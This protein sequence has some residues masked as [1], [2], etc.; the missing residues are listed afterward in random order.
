M[1]LTFRFVIVALAVLVMYLFGFFARDLVAGTP[2]QAS[3]LTKIV[4]SANQETPPPSR[5]FSD[6]FALISSRHIHSQDPEKLIHAGMEGLVA[7]LGD[8]HTN[9][10]R[11]QV[12]EQFAL[13]TKG[14]FVGIG[15]R[16]ADDPLGARIAVVFPDGPA[17][18]SG[19]QSG[20]VISSVD[21]KPVAGQAVDEIVEQIRGEA[22]TK[23]RLGI[24]RD[25]KPVT[26]TV[27]RRRVDIPTV[28][29]EML[30]S[31]IGYVGVSGFSGVTPKQFR[32]AVE[33]LHSQNPTGLI[34]D[35]RGNPGG[36]LESAADMLSLFVSGKT[37]VTMKLRGGIVKSTKAPRDRTL[38]INYP[39]TILIDGDS[40]SA[41]EIMAGVLRDYGKATIIG[42]HSYGKASVQDLHSLPQGANFKVTIAKYYLPSGADITR[43]VDEYGSYLSGGIKPDIEVDFERKDGAAFAVP[44]KD[45]QLDRAIEFIKS[46]FVSRAN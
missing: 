9:Y 2:P 39:V 40:A 10:L 42:T 46:S 13:E 1:K 11:P 34:I 21:T 25:G 43:K 45:S 16:L 27:V 5:V 28:T 8:P 19:V 20:D 36:L 22:G 38:P 35:L 30:A 33:T 23:V 41:S 31:N 12:A 15:A 6:A 17:Q 37:I 18:E 29:S 26:I 44:G 4:N 24:V 14:D 7:S 32:Q 3:K